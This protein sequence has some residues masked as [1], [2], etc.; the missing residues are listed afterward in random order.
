MRFRAEPVAAGQPLSLARRL[1]R[2]R[3]AR[4]AAACNCVGAKRVRHRADAV[5]GEPVV[6]TLLYRDRA[7]RLD[8]TGP[9]P[10]FHHA[11]A[12]PGAGVVLGLAGY[13]RCWSIPRRN[14]RARRCL[15]GDGSAN[16]ARLQPAGDDVHHL[17]SYRPGDPR[18]A[19]AWKPRRAATR[20][21]VRE[22]EQPLA[23]RSTLD[24]RALPH[25]PY[26]HRIRRL[27]RWVDEAEREGRR[28]RLRLP[29]QPALGPDTAARHRH[30]L[31]ARAGAAAAMPRDWSTRP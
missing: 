6:A 14:R 25:L 27:A 5:A 29:G 4:C 10:R 20:L 23:A 1:V 2:R 30:L 18:R 13:L 9:D 31:P 28:Y 16:H 15:P 7:T 26:E 11:A 17:R 3:C 24:W 8:R 12:G 21:L 19:I 22:Y